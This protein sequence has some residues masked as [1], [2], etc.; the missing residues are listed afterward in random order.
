MISSL[1]VTSQR[2]E[3]QSTAVL[4]LAGRL[5]ATTVGQ[6]ERALTDAQLSGNRVIVIDLSDLTYVSSSGL[7]VLLTGRSNTRKR[8]GEVFLCSLRPP[9]REVFEMVGFT[10]VFTIFDTLE[11]A[12]EAAAAVSRG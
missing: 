11:Q 9:V 2:V 3:G 6:L 5:D 1:N 4:K 8:G 12:M 7:R 10:A